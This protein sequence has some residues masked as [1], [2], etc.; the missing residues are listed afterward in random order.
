MADKQKVPLRTFSADDVNKSYGSFFRD[1]RKLKLGNCTYLHTYFRTVGNYIISLHVVI[2][3]I[4]QNIVAI[5]HLYSTSAV[6]RK[7][8]NSSAEQE[9]IFS[10]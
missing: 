5:D 9:I 4:E 8:S 3:Y 1:G 6:W 10:I 2:C 7:S